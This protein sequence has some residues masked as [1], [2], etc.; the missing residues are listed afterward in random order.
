M[1]FWQAIAFTE[2]DQL[3]DFAR[4]AEE[5]GFAGVATGDHFVTPARIDAE[6]PYSADGK[7]WVRPE[8]STPEPLMLAAALAQ[9]TQRL[10]FMVTVY[11]L[12]MRELFSAAKQISTAGVLTGN[13]VDLGVGVGW[14][15]EEFELTGSDFPTRGRRCDEMLE[16]IGKLL[17]GG[18]VE[19]RGEFYSFA[20]CQMSP[21]PSEPVPIIVG[22]HTPAAFRRAARHAGWLAAHY[23]VQDVPPLVEQ[24]RKEC[25]RAGRADIGRVVVAIND[26]KERD[27][28]QRLEDAGVSDVINMPLVFRGLSTSSLQAKRDA[29]ETFA[30][31]FMR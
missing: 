21:V 31:R 5:I 7:P 26:L 11:I 22:G 23:D 1:Q 25:A 4:A 18:M 17:Q 29:M 8:D 27:Q 14:M 28:V 16:V 19:H 24:Y 10:R 12:P 6:Y 3:V 30:Q 15:R 9:V 2:P 13:R 20:P